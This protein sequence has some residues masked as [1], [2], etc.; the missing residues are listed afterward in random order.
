MLRLEHDISG[1]FENGKFVLAIFFDLQ[2]AYDTTW[3]REVLR[4]LLSL[5]F[6]GHLPILIRNLLTIRN[7]RV[8]V[9]DT[10]SPSFDQIEGIPQGSV[11]RVLCFALAFNDIVTAVPKEVSCS[12]YVDE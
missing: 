10:L 12:F 11:L 6:Y 2:K 9:G 5:G 4:K 3:K 8:R 1:A 7:F